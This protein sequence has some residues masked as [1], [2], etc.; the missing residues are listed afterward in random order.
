M[1]KKKSKASLCDKCAG[2]CCRYIA[3]PLEN[4]E[5]REDYEDIRWYLCH[6]D[7]AVFVEDGEWYINVKNKCKYLCEKDSKCMM[8]EGRPKICRKYH[9]DDCEFTSDEYG[10][11]LHFTDDKQMAEYIKIKFDNNK[12]GKAK[13]KSKKA[14]KS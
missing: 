9:T 4:P 3:L 14:K 1:A 10:Y 11:E 12:T 13:K 6:E 5:D 7:V 2:L 8:Y